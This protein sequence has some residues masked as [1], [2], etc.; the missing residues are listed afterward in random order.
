[1]TSTTRVIYGPQTTML[2]AVALNGA[3]STRTSAAI[4]VRGWEFLRVE[5]ACVLDGTGLA[6]TNTITLTFL[7][8]Q[9]NGATYWP[10]LKVAS[11]DTASR[12]APAYTITAADVTAL[13]AAGDI[14]AVQVTGLTHIKVIATG[15]GAPDGDN[16]ITV[17]ARSVRE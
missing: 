11:D 13:I 14:G 4:D 7:S 15:S 1:M 2:S 17:R 8:S 16:T 5:F 10:L 6:A 9:D 3:E 12:F